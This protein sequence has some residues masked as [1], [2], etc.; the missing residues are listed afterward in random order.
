M[1]YRNFF[2]VFILILY[3]IGCEDDLQREKKQPGHLFPIVKTD[4]YGYINEHGKILIKPRFSY[5]N[6]FSEGLSAVQI[7][8]RYGYIDES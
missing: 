3:L 7:D 6:S 1:L 8:G 4:E 2:L 5:A